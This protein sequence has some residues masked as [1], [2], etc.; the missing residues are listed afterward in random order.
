MRTRLGYGGEGGK[1]GC[2]SFSASE[3][4]GGEREG[5][6]KKIGDVFRG[7]EEKRRKEKRDDHSERIREKR[8]F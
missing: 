1:K 4:K 3:V 2:T 6:R 8:G 7:R 5:S